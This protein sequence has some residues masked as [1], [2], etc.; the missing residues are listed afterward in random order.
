MPVYLFADFHSCIVDSMLLKIWWETFIALLVKRYLACVN[1]LNIT[2]SL[3]GTTFLKFFNLAW[4]IRQSEHLV[5]IFESLL[6]KHSTLFKCLS[7]Y[8][9]TFWFVQNKL[10]YFVDNVMSLNNMQTSFW[11]LKTLKIFK[12]E[13]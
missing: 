9:S 12:Y 5:T 11:I 10:D 4:I 8:S 7:G 13:K 2:K 6:C 3:N 1:E